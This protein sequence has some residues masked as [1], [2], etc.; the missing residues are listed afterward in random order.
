MKLIKNIFNDLMKWFF[1][2]LHE[3]ISKEKRLK[4]ME[5]IN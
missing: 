2:N 5:M 4:P 1:F 3:I